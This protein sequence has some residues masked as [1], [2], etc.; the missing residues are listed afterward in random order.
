MRV[1]AQDLPTSWMTPANA[2][3]DLTGGVFEGN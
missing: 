2:G 3:D 1:V